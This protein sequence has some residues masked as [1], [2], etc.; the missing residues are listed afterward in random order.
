MRSEHFPSHVF[1]PLAAKLQGG[2]WVHGQ[3]A[4]IWLRSHQWAS[5]MSIGKPIRMWWCTLVRLCEHVHACT[6]GILEPVPCM[7]AL[8]LTCACLGYDT[9]SHW[10]KRQGVRNLCLPC[11][12]CIVGPF[13]WDAP[14]CQRARCASCGP[15]MCSLYARYAPSLCLVC[16]L[17][18]QYAPMT[19]PIC[20]LCFHYDIV[21]P[22]CFFLLCSENRQHNHSQE[23]SLFMCR[24]IRSSN[25]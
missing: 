10:V 23:Q 1:V 18:A 8:C 14:M 24:V 6:H 15:M 21:R 20:L 16:D 2:S 9:P 19:P 3:I 4:G 11:L 25:R 12:R 5:G 17:F 7:L 13:T 22:P